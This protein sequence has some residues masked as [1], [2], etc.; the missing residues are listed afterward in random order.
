MHNMISLDKK[1][2]AIEDEKG[3]YRWYLKRLRYM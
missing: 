2:E 1:V 3:G